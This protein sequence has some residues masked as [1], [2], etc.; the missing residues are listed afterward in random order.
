[1]SMA[2]VVIHVDEG[3]DHDRRAQL[4][5]MVGSHAGVAAVTNHDEK[6]HLMNVQY[7]PSTVSA[8]MLLD[9]VRQQGVHAELVGL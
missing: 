5:D 8:H 1:M 7:D 4:A 2:D 9:A 3:L 6:P